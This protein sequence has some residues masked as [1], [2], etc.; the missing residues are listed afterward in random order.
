MIKGCHTC[1]DNGEIVLL[2]KL[3]SNKHKIK[4]KMEIIIRAILTLTM[5]F[6]HYPRNIS[7]RKL[8]P[9]EDCHIIQDVTLSRVTLSKIHIMSYMGPIPPTYPEINLLQWISLELIA[10]AY[11]FRF[12]LWEIVCRFKRTSAD[13]KGLNDIFKQIMQLKRFW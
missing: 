10:L 2:F 9:S 1:L 12:Y 8:V 11:I 7:I 5:Y 3:L 13:E 6:S 4:D